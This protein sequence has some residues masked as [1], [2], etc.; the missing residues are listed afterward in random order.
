M[1]DIG[2][3]YYFTH[4]LRLGAFGPQETFHLANPPMKRYTYIFPFEPQKRGIPVSRVTNGSAELLNKPMEG[5]SLRYPGRS[6][7]GNKWRGSK[8]PL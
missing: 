2:L 4:L 5:L 1:E 7:V 6:N 8:V 3:E